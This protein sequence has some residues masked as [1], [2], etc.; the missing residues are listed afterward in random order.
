MNRLNSNFTKQREK[1]K[2]TLSQDMFEILTASADA[3][4]KALK[5][6]RALRRVVPPIG[7]A[8]MMEIAS[9]FIK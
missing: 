9:R 5:D 2:T 1:N 7:M 6:A 8:A 3:K 4:K